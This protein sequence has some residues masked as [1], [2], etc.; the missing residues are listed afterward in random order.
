MPN[1]PFAQP[2][3][4]LSVLGEPFVCH[5]CRTGTEFVQR[6]VNMNT[7]GMSFLNLDWLN[8]SGDGAICRTC[9]Y[10][11]VFMGDAHEWLA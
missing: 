3:T 9:G 5:V 8:K 1:P 10:I 2:R 4:R 11:H 7:K 6:E